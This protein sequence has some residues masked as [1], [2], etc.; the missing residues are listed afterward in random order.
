M[1][2]ELQEY[3]LMDTRFR[4]SMFGAG[5]LWLLVLTSCSTPA[6]C[7]TCPTVDL[8]LLGPKALLLQNQDPSA[9]QTWGR[10]ELLLSPTAN[11]FWKIPKSKLQ[12]AGSGWVFSSAFNQGKGTDVI[13]LGKEEGDNVLV[14]TLSVSVWL[15]NTDISELTSDKGFKVRLRLAESLSTSVSFVMSGFVWQAPVANSTPKETCR[16]QFALGNPGY[17]VTNGTPVTVQGECKSQQ[18]GCWQTCSAR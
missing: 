2:H 7:P 17:F 10:I 13:L 4:I 3:T 12:S 18:T 6:S 1:D 15:G 16:G 9:A 11:G 5:L 8:H 14:S